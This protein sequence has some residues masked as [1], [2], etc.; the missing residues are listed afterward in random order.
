[1]RAESAVRIGLLETSQDHL[2]PSGNTAL[3]G[4]KLLI[5]VEDFPVLDMIEHV[6]LASD[7]HFQDRFVEC[8]AF[9]DAESVPGR[10]AA[11]EASLS[12]V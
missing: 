5:G 11:A 6:G 3:R 2:V 4:A 8:M 7:P 9:P 1:V 12:V 10:H